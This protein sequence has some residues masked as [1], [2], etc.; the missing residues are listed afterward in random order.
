MRTMT[1][2]MVALALAGCAGPPHGRGR[3]HGFGPGGPGGRHIGGRLFISPMGEP[4]RVADGDPR[5]AWFDAADAD[6]DGRLTLAEFQADA[7]RFFAMLDLNHD[8]EI[9]PDEIDHYETRVAPEIRTG[10]G[11]AG[12]GMGRGGG[13]RGMG[14][15]HRGGSGMGGGGMGHR[16]MGGGEGPPDGG[17][18]DGN[19]GPKEPARQGAARFGLLDLPEPVTA[20][21][22]D[23]NRGVSAQEFDRAAVKRFGALDMD[24]QG[25]LLRADILKMA[26]GGSR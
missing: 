16:G 22:A 17:A 25:V 23:F 15:G 1:V 11:I 26:R 4:F 7:R 2:A 12:G 9:D 13:G 20:A 10:G 3:P 21:D 6:H 19:R 24:H 18:Q 14:G 5:A 8:G